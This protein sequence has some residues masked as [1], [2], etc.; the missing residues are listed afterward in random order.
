MLIHL[1]DQRSGAY[2]NSLMADEDPMHAGRWLI[3]GFATDVAP[4]D[5]TGATWP[6]WKDGAWSLLPDYR[7]RALYRTDTGEPAQM[8]VAGVTPDQAGLTDRPRPSHEY[9]WTD[10]AWTISPE[11]VARNEKEAAMREFSRRLDIAQ[12][13][14]LGKSD[15]QAVGLLDDVGLAQ[16]KAWAT[17]QMQLV[18]TINAPD[19]PENVSWPTEPDNDAIRAQIE[20]SRTATEVADDAKPTVSGAN[21]SA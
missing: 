14:T 9:V 13:A 6:F 5:R 19:F 12:R 15:A 4:P 18:S 10:G 8:T 11:A 21:V 20:A 1:Y 17:Y 3:P 2:T 16:Y 7:G